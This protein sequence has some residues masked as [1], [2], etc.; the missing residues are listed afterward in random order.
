MGAGAAG[1]LAAVVLAGGWAALGPGPVQADGNVNAAG[2]KDQNVSHTPQLRPSTASA[3][4]VATNATNLCNYTPTYARNGGWNEVQ[5]RLA[6]GLPCLASTATDYNVRMT[7]YEIKV[8]ST[9]AIT[10]G[11]ANAV[12][13]ADIE[14]LIGLSCNDG[15][16][17][18]EPGQT[19]NRIY[20][21]R[22]A[23]S[24]DKG[25]YGPDDGNCNEPGNLAEPTFQFSV[26]TSHTG[27]VWLTLWIQDNHGRHGH[28]RVKYN[29]P[30]Q[31]Q[32]YTLAVPE[33]AQGVLEASDVSDPLTPWASGTRQRMAV[34]L[35]TASHG[36][37]FSLSQTNVKRSVF[38]RVT[39]QLAQDPAASRE[40]IGAKITDASGARLSAC[41]SGAAEDICRV[42]SANWP[43]GTG[44]DPVTGKF[45]VWLEVPSSYSG[46]VYLVMSAVKT[47]TPPVYGV[48][49]EVHWSPG[50]PAHPLV[51]P[52]RDD[53]NIITGDLS[54]MTFR[55]KPR[56]GIQAAHLLVYTSA[57]TSYSATGQ[58]GNAAFDRGTLRVS[59]DAAG[60]NPI[61][62]ARL[63]EARSTSLAPGRCSSVDHTCI[64]ANNEF[65]LQ[66]DFSVP[67]S[68][69]GPA[70]LTLKLEKAG[71]QPRT[72]ALKYEA[73]LRAGYPLAARAPGGTV[74]A[75]TVRGL[76]AYAEGGAAQQAAVFIR[77]GGH[78]DAYDST[79]ANLAKTGID[80]ATIKIT[81]DAAGATL[82]TGAKISSDEAGAT[83]LTGCTGTP[84]TCT[85]TAANW[86]GTTTADR[87]DLWF[88]VPA[89]HSGPAYLHVETTQADRRNG[90]FALAYA[91]TVDA[92]PLVMPSG[93]SD[94]T[95]VTARSRTFAGSGGT[96]QV[97]VNLRAAAHGGAYTASAANTAS[98]QFDS[99]TV[100]V[101]SDAAGAS[102]ITGAE[103]SSDAA[104]NTAIAG[105]TGTPNTCTIT[106]ADW[107]ASSGTTT[108]LDLYFSVPTGHSGDTY[109]VLTARK[110]G[111]VMRRFAL[112]YSDA[113]IGAVPLL[114][115]TGTLN[116][117]L[118][119]SLN[120]QNMA[121]RT[122]RWLVDGS[123]THAKIFLRAAAHNN[124]Y[125]PSAANAARSAFDTVRIRLSTDPSGD[126]EYAGL[127][128]TGAATVGGTSIC[129]EASAGPT[130]TISSA[131]WPESSGTT[132]EVSLAVAVPTTIVGDVYLVGT[133]IQSGK[134]S[135]AFSVRLRDPYINAAP[136]VA[137]APGGVPESGDISANIR[138]YRSGDE[139]QRVRIAIRESGHG[140]EWDDAD[141]NR[142]RSGV[143]AVTLTIG[144]LTSFGTISALSGAAFYAGPSGSD[145]PLV[146]AVAGNFCRIVAASW[147]QSGSPARTESLDLW[148]SVPAATTGD[149]YVNMRVEGGSLATRE[150]RARYKSY[151][152]IWPLPV[153][154]PASGPTHRETG[155]VKT[156]TRNWA[157]GGAA[158]QVEVYLRSVETSNTY[159]GTHT[160]VERS[161][162]DG[163]ELRL[164][165]EEDGKVSASGPVFTGSS[166]GSSVLGACTETSQGPV[167]NITSA[168]WPQGNSGTPLRTLL[169]DVYF[170]VPDRH[171]GPVWLVVRVKKS[172]EGDRVRSIRYDPH[173]AAYPLVVPAGTSD[174]T[175][176]AAGRAQL[177]QRG[178]DT[179]GDGA[180]ATGLARGRLRLGRRRRG[181]FGGDERE[182]HH[183][184][185][186]G[187]RERDHGI[188]DLLGR[189]R[190]HGA[191]GLHGDG[192]RLHHHV[193]E[194]AGQRRAGLLVLGAQR[195]DG[196]RL[197][198]GHRH[199][200]RQEPARGC[201]GVPAA[202]A[203]LPAGGA[204]S[205]LDD[206]RDGRPG[207]AH[208][209]LPH[210]RE[211]AAGLGLPARRLA[212]QHLHIGRGQ[213]GGGELQRGHDPAG[214]QRGRG[215]GD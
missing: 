62:G 87:L 65:A 133:A 91:D 205:D 99:V 89:S 187:G 151:L 104:G 157:A 142:Q 110:S 98:A 4:G 127:E 170:T 45:N 30:Q 107:P 146:C 136:L 156:N 214:D 168:N 203:D 195:D 1:V 165:T 94:G 102:L 20:V 55:W 51:V 144:T 61:A 158:N 47:G 114:V 90:A 182:D 58:A 128:L 5:F 166:G 197:R 96:Q 78:G 159:T 81:S 153:P 129:S 201:F 211:P 93:T 97:Q 196:Q 162:F 208:G 101:A 79:H 11:T 167:C 56:N 188:D 71:Y 77:A 66:A 28:F 116:G 33:N 132:T 122:F 73:P 100:A 192:W 21:H 26:P 189:G 111:E 120:N 118:P 209:Q 27:P 149:V 67:D 193:G 113:Q 34:Y 18:N 48:G 131:N 119:T 212:L 64:L 109:V 106:A 137:P 37:R 75:G 152:R 39:L 52:L 130:C 154:V 54:S 206:L 44:A 57:R 42:S 35:R 164:A 46:P 105:C 191:D 112:S 23:N 134:A 49:S 124:I 175:D 43:A 172:G 59:S 16:W 177:P 173:Y 150:Y 179:A 69:T 143:T 13:G 14:H 103:L 8:S 25:T 138:A 176:L 121:T 12:P 171:S 186:R 145:K 72:Y 135:R 108:A 183:R 163:V 148:F 53:R 213:R 207:R 74:A 178:Q 83:A 82:I 198:G 174:G 169:Q 84:N 85:I 115:P 32:L 204:A 194:L 180:P 140:N 80:S 86:P 76:A 185:R 9:D 38:S 63:L 68:H 40:I 190:E 92:H 7:A 10:H 181:A 210:G 200:Q 15:S 22:T 6:S 215:D 95:L 125:V 126:H 147:P 141:L 19:Y 70:Y 60:S 3:F 17:R 139:R 117:T 184:Q 31:L 50:V 202:A 199:G 161:A 24:P 29:A 160:N 2:W 155:N 41:S 123:N 88:S 36:G